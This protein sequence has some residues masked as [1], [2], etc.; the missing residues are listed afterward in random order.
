MY[1]VWGRDWAGI[2]GA[3]NSGETKEGEGI[4]CWQSRQGRLEK[5]KGQCA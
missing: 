4:S 3:G 1:G 5:L 2:K